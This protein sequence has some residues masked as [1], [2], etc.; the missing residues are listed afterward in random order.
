MN[1]YLIFNII[2]DRIFEKILELQRL[3]TGISKQL[4]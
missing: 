1:E 2:L 4:N 3:K